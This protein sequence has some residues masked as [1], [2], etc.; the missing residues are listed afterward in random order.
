VRLVG[1]VVGIEAVE[2]GLYFVGLHRLALVGSG[3][4]GVECDERR[5]EPCTLCDQHLAVPTQRID[6]VVVRIVEHRGDL[7]ERQAELAEQQ[8][9]LQPQDVGVAVQAIAGRAAL[10]WHDEAMTRRYG[11][12]PREGQA[13]FCGTCSDRL[14][15]AQR[16]QR[17]P[18][19]NR[20]F[21]AARRLR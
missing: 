10:R 6:R 14:R 1:V 2:H 4:R 19:R 12:T 20:G 5:V 11:L 16:S 9:L 17:P 7:V 21:G 18:T 15:E 3:E 13:G 8:D